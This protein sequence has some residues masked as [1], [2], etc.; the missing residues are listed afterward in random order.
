MSTLVEIEAAVDAL[1]W[2]EKQELLLF[3][4]E[5]LR[6]HGRLPQPRRFSTAQVNA[7]ISQ[8]EAD[9]RRFNGGT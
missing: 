1:P 6:A 9:L 8:D 7:W 2:E 5:R 4:A 3:V